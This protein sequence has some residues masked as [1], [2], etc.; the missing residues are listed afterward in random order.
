MWKNV[1]ETS[2]SSLLEEARLNLHFAVQPLASAGESFAEKKPDFS[3]TSFEY[4][5]QTGAFL[6]AEL[7]SK[8]LYA[9]LQ[10]ESLTLALSSPQK[11]QL[12]HQKL[13]GLNLQEALAWLS[14]ALDKNGVRSSSLSFPQYPD[15]PEH[16]L[17]DSAV[18]PSINGNAGGEGLKLL[19]CLYENTHFL[20]SDFLKKH[21][22]KTP[23]R[24][25]PHHF[26][27]A[28]LIPFAE[29]N[30]ENDPSV[31]I[32]FSPGD[33]HY[34]EPYWYFSPWPYPDKFALQELS[35]PGLW[36]TEGFT[37][38]ILKL[39]DLARKGNQQQEEELS[40]FMEEGFFMAKHMVTSK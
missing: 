15:F 9:S 21:Q 7:G 29:N 11:E 26:D 14:N 32:G 38:G 28:I 17:A 24:T 36:H 16:P 4:S 22:L 40:K 25:W 5:P 2:S 10:M 18:F 13:T 12:A 27:M 20:L 23:I 33:V 30:G 35:Y 31:G 34:N 39:S 8:A 6:S 1:H 3:H 19:R 37:A